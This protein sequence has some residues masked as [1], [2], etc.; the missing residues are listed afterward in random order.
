MKAKLLVVTALGVLAISGYAL[1]GYADEA[2][3]E[4]PAAVT[5][6]APA[7]EAPAAV[8]VG[9]TVCPVEG[10]A[11]EMGK[12]AKVEYNGKIYNLCGAMCEQAF[13]ADPEK[14]IATLGEEKAVEGDVVK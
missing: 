6:V 8:E 9:N 4:A 13:L 5:E 3:T 10:N 11:I 14:Y 2:T 1:A 12:E 7:A